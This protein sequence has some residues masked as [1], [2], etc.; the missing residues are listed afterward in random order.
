MTDHER[1]EE[2][3]PLA[4][5][6][7]LDTGELRLVLRHVTECQACASRQREWQLLASALARSPLPAAPA[8]LVERTWARM[9]AALAERAERRWNDAVLGVLLLFGWTVGLL[10]WSVLRLL[11]GGLPAALD[12]DFAGLLAWL[13]ASTVF[14]WITGGVAALLISRRRETAWRNL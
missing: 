2:L 1:M 3:L 9:R 7:A 4:A 14:A 5:A 6:G 10:T 12:I 13:T 8:A 11:W